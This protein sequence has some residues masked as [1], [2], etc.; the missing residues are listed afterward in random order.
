MLIFADDKMILDTE[1]A[2]CIYVDEDGMTGFAIRA[3]YPSFG[4]KTLIDR[5]P[6]DFALVFIKQMFRAIQKGSPWFVVHHPKKP[7]DVKAQEEP[8]EATE[9]TGEWEVDG[10]GSVICHSCKEI[11]WPWMHKFTYC[12]KC[13]A[14]NRKEIGP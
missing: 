12:P 4:N 14:R 1:N 2:G 10:N 9:E 11:F 7:E 5:I 3:S 8:A 13:G 6:E